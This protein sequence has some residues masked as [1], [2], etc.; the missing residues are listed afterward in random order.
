MLTHIRRH[1]R[2][3][4]IKEELDWKAAIDFISECKSITLIEYFI[5]ARFCRL[6][7]LLTVRSWGWWGDRHDWLHR[8]T[9]G[10]CTTI[11]SRW[12]RADLRLLNYPWPS[13]DYPDI[14]TPTI[15][16][17]NIVI[18]STCNLKNRFR[19][20]EPLSKVV[21]QSPKL[22]VLQLKSVDLT[23]W[24]NIKVPPIRELVLDGCSWNLNSSEVDLMWDFSSL[25][26]LQIKPI[27]PADNFFESLPRDNLRQLRRLHITAAPHHHYP[28]VKE[29]LTQ[30]LD[31]FIANGEKLEEI[32][33]LCQVPQLRMTSISKHSRLMILKIHEYTG[34]HYDW[35]IC[36]SFSLKDIA[37]L[38]RSCPRIQ[39]LSL[40]LDSKASE[41]SYH[42]T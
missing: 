42:D 38:A 29:S 26:L 6:R 2:H 10:T 34:F 21:E 15:P 27:V 35:E 31:H 7:Y 25:E 11:K 33:L 32:E 36:P 14:H 16:I 9:H 4:C 37:M 5:Q 3:I 13:K 41:V 19:N 8:N 12:P 24:K 40:D 17:E 1:S 30:H 23:V 18:I 22:K 20:F 39:E 28:L